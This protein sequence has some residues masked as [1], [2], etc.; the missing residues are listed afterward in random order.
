MKTKAKAYLI[1]HNNLPIKASLVELKPG[2]DWSLYY[3]TFGFDYKSSFPTKSVAIK[4]AKAN[5]FSRI[6]AKR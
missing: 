4:A 2:G 1:D 3:S 6:G 5:G